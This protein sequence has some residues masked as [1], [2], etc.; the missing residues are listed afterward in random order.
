MSEQCNSNNEFSGN[1]NCGCGSKDC[2]CSTSGKCNCA[3]KFLE[4]ADAAWTEL[5]KEK[6]KN[7]INSKKGEHMEKLA[8]I[9][10]KAN[11]DKWRTKLS[12]KTNAQEFKNTLKEFFSS[13][14]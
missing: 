6:I 2:G 5:L 11:G 1:G 4:L 9:V 12:S 14:D 3:E 8:E 7:K 13:C 10:A